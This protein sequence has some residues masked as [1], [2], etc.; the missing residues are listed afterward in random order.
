MPA[1][2]AVA[3]TPGRL[4][5]A[6][7]IDG[8]RAQ[9]R[10]IANP[11]ARRAA[12]GELAAVERILAGAFVVSTARTQARGHA[13]DLAR[14]AVAAGIDVVAVVGGDG[15][16]GEVA[17]ALAGSQTALACLPSGTTD[18]FARSLGISRAAQ[19]A[20][21]RLA[22]AAQAGRLPRRAVDL[23]LVNGRHFVGTSGV[24]FSAAMTAAADAAP[25]GKARLG[26]LHFARA[27][28]GQLAGRYLRRPPRMR[29]E[30]AGRT[31]EGVTVVV[32]NTAALTYFGARAIR[33][34][35]AAGVETGGVSLTLLRRARVPVVAGVVA[36]LL[37]GRGVTA[38]PDVAA[39]PAIR[40]AT[41]TSADGEP[42]PLEADGEFLG[43][44]HRI[45]YA[46]APGALRVV[47]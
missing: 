31:A 26:Q 39:F 40:E 21:T 14:E 3:R 23:G 9:V 27:A 7:E 13:A 10:I 33:V 15:T 32:Q 6:R 18:A 20:A 4:A 28:A 1:A 41:V 25:D 42:L 16:V 38:H 12:P 17:G 30:A 29:V 22:A 11:A 44:H 34:C 35:A 46:V 43:L 45:H 37:W 24:G 47:A 5:H 2:Q 19:T 8:R 36:R